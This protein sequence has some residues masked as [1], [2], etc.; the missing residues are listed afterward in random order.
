MKVPPRPYHHG[1][2]REA[3]LRA[4]ENALEMGGVQSLTLRE[5]SRELGVSHTSPLRHFA[6]KQALLDGL[7]VRGFARLG[8]VLSRAVKDRGLDFSARLTRLARA[9]VGFQ[10]KHPALCALM[11]EAKHRT[12]APPELL[13]AGER[14]FSHGPI[15]FAEGQ[16]RGE[17]AAGDP[18]RLSLVAFAALQG[19][20]TISTDGKFKG[21]SLDILVPEVIERI[22][23][24]LRPNPYQLPN[25]AELHKS[26]IASDL[27]EAFA[28]TSF[29]E[30]RSGEKKGN[31]TAP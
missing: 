26:F 23:L 24:G 25:P 29:P 20:I 1:N 17:V 4:A 18:A 5:L 8:A 22:I 2:L 16:A 31:R 27:K 7:A 15:I 12:D 30:S 3:L 9:Y 13:E 6:N 19:L 21:T 28:K 11:F 10:T 14:A